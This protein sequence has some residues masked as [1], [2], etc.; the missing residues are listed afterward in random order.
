MIS[1]D[2]TV[3]EAA[4]PTRLRMEN[5]A[6]ALGT[7]DIIVFSLRRHGHQKFVS[8]QLSLYPTNAMVRLLYGW[9]ALR[10]SSLKERFDAVTVQDPFEVGLVGLIISWYYRVPLQVQVHTDL[11]APEFK[12][13]SFLNRIRLIIARIVLRRAD[14]VRVVSDRI[15]RGVELHVKEAARSQISVLPIFVDIDH[16]KT[17]VAPRELIDRFAKFSQKVLVVSRLESEKNVALAV[18]SFAEGAPH[19]ACLIIV[20]EGRQQQMLRDLSLSL[21]IN[22]RVFFEGR[23]DPAPYYALADLLLS[24]SLYEGYGMTIIEALAAGVPVISNDVGIAPESGALIT[25]EDQWPAAIRD[26]LGKKIR[27]VLITYPYTDWNAYVSA[28]RN[29]IAACLPISRRLAAFGAKKPLLGFIGQGFIGKS[30]A[31]DFERRGFSTVRFAL[32]EPYRAN[33]DKIKDCDITFIAVPTPTVPAKTEGGTVSVATHFDYHIVEQSLA[34]IGKGKTAVIKSTVLPG[35]T[36]RLQEKFPDIIVI[37]SPEFLSAATAAYDAA[38]PFSN[39]AGMGKDTPAHMIAAEAVLSILPESAFAQVCMSTEAEIIKY[40]HN[41]SA[42][43]Q[44][45]MFNLMYDLASSLGYGWDNIRDAI[46]ADPFIARR[47]ARPVHKSGRGAGGFC[48]IKDVAA[49]REVYER[50]LNSDTQGAHFLRAMELKNI[51][52]LRDTN[53]DLDLL[54]GV[55]GSNYKTL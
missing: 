47:Y 8:G 45:I 12:E 37:Y 16:F 23:G 42:Y 51:Q 5:Y 2:R 11:F 9:N 34:L 13:H 46:E 35:T 30:Y 17:T 10:S 21:G 31:D 48:F 53:K 44:I 43:A 33:Q 40:T 27:G 15:R 24:P 55:Y 29:D 54:E 52:L 36:A 28:W 19:D 4:S 7:L 1:T 39:I 38:H 26:T 22:E 41:S 20:G 3:F 25:R 14:R 49:L 32:E 50:E 6:K 18:R